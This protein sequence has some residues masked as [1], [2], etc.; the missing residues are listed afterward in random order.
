MMS[1]RAISI[2][3][4]NISAPACCP[5]ASVMA[6]AGTVTFAAMD[7][8]SS[9][10]RRHHLWLRLG[11]RRPAFRPS[12][13]ATRRCSRSHLD[14]ATGEFTATLVNPLTHAPGEGENN[15]Q[16]G[17][18][19]YGHQ[20]QWSD[21][22]RH[23]DARYRRRYAGDRRA[24]GKGDS[25]PPVEGAGV[26]EDDLAGIREWHRSDFR[27]AQ[28]SP[29]A[30]TIAM[31]WVT[32]VSALDG[33]VA[34]D[35]AVAFAA[36][37]SA[38]DGLTSTASASNTRSPPAGT[39]SPLIGSMPKDNYIDANG[40]GVI[41]GEGASCCRAQLS[42]GA[43]LSDL[44]RWARFGSTLIGTISITLDLNG[45]VPPIR[46]PV[47]GLRFRWRSG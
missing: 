2:N 8:T 39:C 37:L 15:L 38:P 40:A 17:L 6:G 14:Q 26:G 42:H 7:G 5:T 32:P 23:P 41:T 11:M 46:F 21:R 36:G 47:C 1:I 9:N 3:A 19:Y 35:R 28:Y 20:R 30:P 4:S 34:G 18:T 25:I 13:S 27:F 31:V 44:G 43:R 16:I 24:E 33:P 10:H 22:S 29:G 12:V 45:D